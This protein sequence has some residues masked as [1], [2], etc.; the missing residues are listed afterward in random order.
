MRRSFLATLILISF[1]VLCPHS[2][3][4]ADEESLGREAEHAGKYREALTH[5]V[6]ALQSASE[7]SSNDQ[8]L[9]EKIISLVQKITPPP[10]VPE[11]AEK[12]LGR[13]RAAVEIAKTPDDFLGA[14]TE[15]KKAARLAPWIASIY[16]N[17]G[18]VQEKT[19]KFDDAMRSYKLYLTAAPSAPD[20]SDV[21]SRLYGLELKAERQQKEDREKAASAERELQK[22]AVLG[23]FIRLVEGN[24]YTATICC[25]SNPFKAQ[26]STAGCNEAEYSGNNWYGGWEGYYKFIFT[27]NEKIILHRGG[28]IEEDFLTGTVEGSDF[29]SIRWTNK[30]G[31]SVWMRFNSDWSS[32]TTSYDRPEYGYDPSKRYGYSNYRRR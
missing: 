1:I 27:S 17:L 3:L 4:A 9:R 14:I 7:G 22:L 28:D 18:V 30:E 21:R 16:F 2:S 31:K 10:A 29:N 25:W 15:F 6:S 12:Y 24:T 5:Y 23:R 26:R 11:G 20:A 19:G 13:G 8:Q 32:F